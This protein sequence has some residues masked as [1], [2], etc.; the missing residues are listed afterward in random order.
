[1]DKITLTKD[2]AND[3][4]ILLDNLLLNSFDYDLS[5]EAIN[6]IASIKAEIDTQLDTLKKWVYFSNFLIADIEKRRGK[7]ERL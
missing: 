7:Y 3:L 5:S 4:S 6:K 1:M 2:N